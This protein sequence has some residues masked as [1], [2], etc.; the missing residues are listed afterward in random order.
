[1]DSFEKI[2]D[3]TTKADDK[4]LNSS[5]MYRDLRSSE[6]G[7]VSLLLSQIEGT[8]RGLFEIRGYE[9]WIA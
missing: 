2:W 3:Y 5:S 1:M 8:D 9:E 7:N 6:I 4:S